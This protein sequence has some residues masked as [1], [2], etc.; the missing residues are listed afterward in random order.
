MHGSSVRSDSA[1]V[2]RTNSQQKFPGGGSVPTSEQYDGKLPTRQM[3]RPTKATNSMAPGVGVHHLVHKSG[4]YPEPTESTS[5]LPQ[6]NLYRS[7]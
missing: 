7:I 4:P 3:F 2:C 6:A 5:N 1:H